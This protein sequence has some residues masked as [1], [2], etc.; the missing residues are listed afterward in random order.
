MSLLN[1]DKS[2][3][4]FGL[5]QLVSD[6][7]NLNSSSSASLL[8]ASSF[9]NNYNNQNISSSFNSNKLFSV[10]QDISNKKYYH[11]NLSK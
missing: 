2:F 6:D 1:K 11:Y 5:H 7:F 8:N 10:N 4:K 9:N 3:K